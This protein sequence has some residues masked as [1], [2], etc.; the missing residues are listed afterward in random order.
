[1]KYS[2]VKCM[3]TVAILSI[4]LGCSQ[5][6][7]VPEYVYRVDLEKYLKEINAYD[8]L[9]RSKRFIF[10]LNPDGCSICSGAV[11]DSMRTIQADEK[12]GVLL[13]NFACNYLGSL[14]G[15]RIR[16]SL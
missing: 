16:I 1:M 14:G 12:I 3:M 4:S 11:L 15:K 10:L 13:T 9:I 8:E 6:E 2:I 5:G 7:S